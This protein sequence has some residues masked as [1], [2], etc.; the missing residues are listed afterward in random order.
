MKTMPSKQVSFSVKENSYT[1]K[2]PNNGQ[3]IE[4]ESMKSL[5]TR[6]TYNDIAAG[7][8]VS[9]QYAKVTVDMIAFF[10]VCC[11]QLRKDL[12]VES[13]SQLEMIDSK[14][15]LQTYIKTIMPWLTEWEIALNS[16]EEEE[17]KETSEQ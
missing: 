16:I 14:V 2:F 7:G 4:V 15:L 9:S 1:V 12:A 10:H 11:P 6:T 5:L 3:F 8:S 17:Q 13:F